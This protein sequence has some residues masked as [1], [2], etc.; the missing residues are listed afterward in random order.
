MTA[1]PTAPETPAETD[2]AEDLN[3][4]VDELLARL[5]EWRD[6]PDWRIV[7]GMPIWDAI[8]NTIE[9]FD[10]GMLPAR[11]RK[12]SA[13]VVDRLAPAWE[14][15][16][17]Q[18]DGSQRPMD[19]QPP[20]RFWKAIG[21]VATVRPTSE[22]LENKPVESVK[23]LLEHDVKPR[24]VAEIYGWYT[25]SNQPDTGKVMD[26]Y[27]NPGKHTK[28]WVNPIYLRQLREQQSAIDAAE[29]DNEAFERKRDR[30]KPNETI[31]D[32]IQQGLTSTQIAEMH[33]TTIDAVNQEADRL[34]LPR[35]PVTYDVL[36]KNE[37]KPKPSSD[38]APTAEATPAARGQAAEK[39]AKPAKRAGRP[40]KPV[41]SPAEE[42]P[43]DAVATAELSD[44]QATIAE[45]FAQDK[46][47]A[48]IAALLN[49]PRT[50]VDAVIDSLG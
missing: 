9:A 36:G 40:A 41:A 12:L 31:G 2:R 34:S 16:A 23:W 45:L 49:I 32:L 6:S 17:I 18:R 47:A 20:E 39:P 15:F 25:A 4:V 35:P 33:N 43:T 14:S 10:G 29:A 42:S 26:E 3:A 7:P 46:S 37:K 19:E 11:C 5:K 38:E 13:A 1:I 21:E 30:R 24:Q 28:D 44:E 22:V 50:R 48:D 27:A 8:E